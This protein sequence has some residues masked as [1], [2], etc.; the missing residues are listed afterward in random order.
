MALETALYTP[1]SNDVGTG[2][3][4]VLVIRLSPKFPPISIIGCKL[5]FVIM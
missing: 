5:F 4:V 2:V 1:N 3:D